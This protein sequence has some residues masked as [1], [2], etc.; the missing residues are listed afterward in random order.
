MTPPDQ[1]LHVGG[2]WI[3]SFAG[4]LVSTWA[5]F[6][7]E[8][9]GMTIMIGIGT[10]ILTGIKVAQEI[11]AWLLRDEEQQALRKLW[12]KMNRKSRPAK[13]DDGAESTI[14]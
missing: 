11:R 7:G 1:H 10:I 13:L 6:A 2:S 8:A 5:W 12:E 3:T 9:N 4:W 14:Q